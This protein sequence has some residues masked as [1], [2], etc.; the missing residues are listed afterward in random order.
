MVPKLMYCGTTERFTWVKPPAIDADISLGKWG[1]VGTF[2]NGGGYVLGSQT[3]H[4]VYRLAWN[5]KSSQDIY[6]ILDY[7]D[8]VYG[9]GLFY[10]LDPFA[11]DTNVLPQFWA[12]PRLAAVDAP[13]FIR[14]QRPTL[15]N[16]PNNSY[17]YPTKS[18]VYTIG[19]SDYIHEITVPVPPGYTF[20]MGVHGS[21][22]GTAAVTVRNLDVG[23]GATLLP[24]DDLLPGEELVLSSPDTVVE[25]PMLPVTTSYRMN[26]AISNVSGVIISF[27][28]EGLLTLSGMIA[29]VLPEGI[30]PDTGNFISGRGHSGCRFD[31]T[32]IQ[33]TATSKALD[34]ISA[35]AILVETGAWE[36]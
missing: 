13:P 24:A 5:T 4:K 2:I 33:V 18:A 23:V 26:T 30:T 34:L 11:M 32:N 16:T 1:S 22:S 35:S 21:S 31:P 14:G 28:G 36:N 9:D 19:T 6:D 29:Q 12:S 8:G 27:T 10:F 20:W 25:I 15:I 7:A 3:G 17:S